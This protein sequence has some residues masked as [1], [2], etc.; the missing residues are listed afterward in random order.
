MCILPIYIDVKQ[1]IR[2]FIILINK[3]EYK[4][5]SKDMTKLEQIK[6]LHPFSKIMFVFRCGD[7][8]I[9]KYLTAN[10]I[11]NIIAEGPKMVNQ[12]LKPFNPKNE[13]IHLCLGSE[14]IRTQETAFATA[15]WALKNG[16][17]L[18]GYRN[19]THLLG[20]TRVF[21][22]FTT[23]AIEQMKLNE[24]S[25]LEALAE[26]NN[27]FFLAWR[28]ALR[29]WVEKEFFSIKRNQI[30]LVPCH[31]STVGMIYYL[32]ENDL[33]LEVDTL[34]GVFLIEKLNGEIIAVK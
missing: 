7:I 23:E 25:L 20:G 33:K 14:E 5:K 11:E 21:K 26:V 3:I 31:A 4:P 9:N 27:P 1:Y 34:E 13:E 10:S 30:M 28:E 15:T 18:K 24:L 2:Y 17:I 29:D 6:K 19:S 8:N 32:F 16:A 12:N 22:N